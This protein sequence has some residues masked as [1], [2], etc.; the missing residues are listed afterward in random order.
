MTIRNDSDRD[1]EATVVSATEAPALL[2]RVSWGAIFA[3]TVI[4]LGILFLLGLLGAAIGLAAIDPGAEDPLSGIGI[5]A[6]V[7]WALASIIALGIG[8]FVAGRLSGIPDNA[9]STA[10][11]ASVWGLVTLVTLWLATS[12]VGAV[13]NT[14]TGA[15]G[16][17]MQTAAQATEVRDVPADMI[18][19]QAEEAIDEV[20]PINEQQVRERAERIA[21]RSAANISNS[22]WYAFF[23]SFLSLIAAIVAAGAGAPKHAMLT[24]RE[25]VELN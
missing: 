8:G 23:A 25:K 6:A 4:A 22:A 12:T 9:S 5:G 13:L 18:E 11:G 10:H 2:S 24:S 3:G 1:I 19:S 21:D 20:R 7:W 15:V 17:V 16:T 14:A